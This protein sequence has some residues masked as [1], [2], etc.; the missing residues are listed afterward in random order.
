MP[1]LW[2]VLQWARRRGGDLSLAAP[3]QQVREVL[4]GCGMT[5]IF[6]VSGSVREVA[7]DPAFPPAPS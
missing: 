2:C 4:E 7:S 6:S 3:Q 1:P 5:G